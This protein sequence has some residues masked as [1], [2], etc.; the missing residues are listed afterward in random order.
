[1]IPA[2]LREWLWKFFLI[3]AGIGLV[4][5]TFRLTPAWA[6]TLPLPIYAELTDDQQQYIVDTLK[7]FLA[8]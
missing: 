6:E 8:K 1:M 3:W 7:A 5:V 4:A 2:R